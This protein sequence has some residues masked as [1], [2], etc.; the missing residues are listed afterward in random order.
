M[1]PP[2]ACSVRGCGRPLSREE[3]RLICTEGHAFDIARSGY[4]SLLQPQ[5]RRSPAP[6]DSKEAVA[7]RARLLAA[8]IGGAAIH[9]IVT[10]VP[11]GPAPLVAVDL[12]CGSGELLGAL[13]G[14]RAVNGV[15]GAR[16]SFTALS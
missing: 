11:D 10:H 12:G 9:A 4:I 5:D 7:A 15:R 14:T 13:A 8:G 6:G 2:L 16:A 1:H 3:R